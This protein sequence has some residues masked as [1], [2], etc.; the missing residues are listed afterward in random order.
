MYP[1]ARRKGEAVEVPEYDF[2]THCRLPTTATAEP[3]HV[4]I[5]E[6]RGVRLLLLL[7]L[8]LLLNA[9]SSEHSPPN[10]PS[11]Q[12]QH[13]FAASSL[14]TSILSHLIHYHRLSIHK[15]GILIFSYPALV[16]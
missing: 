8:L 4:I 13:R 6:V 15:Q 2:A 12:H 5:V 16:K 1:Y 10:N 7:L 11:I 14:A 9:R 3:R